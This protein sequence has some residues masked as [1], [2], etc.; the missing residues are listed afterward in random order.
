MFNKFVAYQSRFFFLVWRYEIFVFLF[1]SSFLETRVSC[2]SGNPLQSAIHQRGLIFI[3]K[4]RFLRLRDWLHFWNCSVNT[5]RTIVI[6]QIC[7]HLTLCYSSWR[8]KYFHFSKTYIYVWFSI[9][10]K[11]LGYVWLFAT[12][13][14]VARLLC[15]WDFPGKNT[16]IGLHFLLPGNFHHFFFSSQG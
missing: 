11:L 15:P 2:F 3:L 7:P 16:E 6:D 1:S 10:V 14:T 13:W 4:L 9:V 12:P 5:I 8:W